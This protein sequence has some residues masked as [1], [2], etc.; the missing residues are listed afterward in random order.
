MMIC[1]FW[2]HKT[3]TTACLFLLLFALLFLCCTFRHSRIIL[4]F[5]E[6][7]LVVLF[8]VNWHAHIYVAF[9]VS[10]DITLK[11]KRFINFN[12]LEMDFSPFSHFVPI[13]HDTFFA[14]NNI[15]SRYLHSA[16]PKLIQFWF[17][18][19][20]YWHHPHHSFLKIIIITIFS[21]MNISRF[22]STFL[23][24]KKYRIYNWNKLFLK[25]KSIENWKE[26]NGEEEKVWRGTKVKF[27]SILSLR[28]V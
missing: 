24:R 8:C 2:L 11:G 27:I 5:V 15:I 17:E 28:E 3:S 12:G 21:P 16:Y 1:W 18:P 25:V 22:L 6:F 14:F 23:L 9:I 26:R 13:K 19:E 7:R 4:L 10:F 20:I